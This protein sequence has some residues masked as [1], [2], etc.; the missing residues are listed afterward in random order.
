MTKAQRLKWNTDVVFWMCAELDFEVKKNTEFHF[1]LFHP[2]RGR[3][4][5]WPSTSNALWFQKNKSYGKP[6]R[7][8]DIEQ[9]L[10]KHFN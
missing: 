9:Y 3:M 2:K 4:D 10:M 6:F 7:I 1:S 5:Y 8:D